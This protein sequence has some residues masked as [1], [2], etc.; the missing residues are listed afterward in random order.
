[1]D[2]VDHI[3]DGLEAALVLERELGVRF[4][5]CSPDVF[6]S[7]PP[8]LRAPT[9]APAPVP[10]PRAVPPPAK[11]SVSAVAQADDEP[12]ARE[13]GGTEHDFVFLHDRPLSPRGR[14]MMDKIV[15]AMGK[16]A[17]TAPVVDEKPVPKAKV[18]IV[19]GA[20][21]LR[22]FQPTLRGA[23]GMW[24]KTGR[25]A[26]VLVT[27]SPEYI[28]RFKEVTPAVEK[29]KRDMWQSLKSVV[30]KLAANDIR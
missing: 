16:T 10:L 28:L 12:K 27:Y 26:D 3:L 21:A 22:K 23:P 14:E 11:P 2:A 30:R 24:L 18:Y 13:K 25:G 6:R 9:P 15:A 8:L 19:L 5:E 29:I 1:M 4:V 7:S 20:L 17:E